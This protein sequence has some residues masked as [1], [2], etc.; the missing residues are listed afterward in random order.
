MVDSTEYACRKCHRPIKV[1][2]P[3]DLHT[4]P[5][6]T[7]PNAVDIIEQENICENCKT[8]NIVYWF[9]PESGITTL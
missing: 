7:R 8:V 1:A 5:S 4:E 9:A 6:I 3:D 2:K